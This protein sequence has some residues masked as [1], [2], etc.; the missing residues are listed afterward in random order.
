MG[1]SATAQD[2][3]DLF[4]SEYVEGWSN[5]KALEIYNPTDQQIDL[6]QYFVARYNNGSTS[7]TSSQTSSIAIQLV[8]TLDP[9]EVHVGV[10]DKRDE[11]GTGQDAPVWDELQA[12]ADQFYCPIY[13]DS[14]AFYFNGNDAIV[15]Y[16]GDVNNIAGAAVIDVFGKVGEDPS[17]GDGWSSDFPY[18][19][20]AGVI[21]TK[22][23]SMIRKS[24]V[25]KGQ[26][27]PFPSFFDPLSE[28]DS[29][30]AVVE[31]GGITVGNWTSLG[32]H[33]CDCESLSIDEAT[34]E[35]NVN[36]APNPS[37]GVFTVNNIANYTNIEVINSLGQEVFTIDNKGKSSVSI[38]LSNRRGV[39][40][41][42]LNGNGETVTRRVIIK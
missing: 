30:P 5:N 4:I 13:G 24:T 2:C 20:G 27:N 26:T 21:V 23:H 17:S 36:I 6:S 18:N 22:D 9:Y 40:F 25:K 42:R 10:I 38:D 28:Y 14:Y 29:I 31:Q 1:V 19:N 12:E 37:N 39:Y 34:A 7:H 8:G 41:V 32:D 3:S 16:K 15:L 11:N 35:F 33:T